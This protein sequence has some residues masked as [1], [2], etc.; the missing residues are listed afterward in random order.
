MASV[1][2]CRVVIP[3]K[4]EGKGCSS[5]GNGGATTTSLEI[6]AVVGALVGMTGEFLKVLVAVK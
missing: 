5:R 2:P 3:A 4:T 6:S 1:T